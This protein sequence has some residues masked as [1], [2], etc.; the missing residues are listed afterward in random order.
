MLEVFSRLIIKMYGCSDSGN[1]CSRIY[2]KMANFVFGNFQ[3]VSRIWELETRKADLYEPFSSDFGSLSATWKPNLENHFEGT[4]FTKV[5]RSMK[6]M[7][8]HHTCCISCFG[9]AIYTEKYLGL[10]MLVLNME[11]NSIF[12]HTR[13]AFMFDSAIWET[14]FRALLQYCQYR[15]TGGLEIFGQLGPSKS[16]EYFQH[17]PNISNVVRIFPVRIFPTPLYSIFYPGGRTQ[18]TYQHN[19]STTYWCATDSM[20]L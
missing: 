18:H 20:V 8:V 6:E 13:W 16:F 10:S 7:T 19:S 5:Y 1:P 4:I 14:N 9:I 3:S 17:C 12:L 15:S 2:S 11:I